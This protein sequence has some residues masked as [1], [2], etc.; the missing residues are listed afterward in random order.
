MK[1]FISIFVLF[2][3]SLSNI[4]AQQELPSPSYPCNAF[5]WVLNPGNV[6]Y[7]EIS[8][9]NLCAQTTYY[10]LPPCVLGYTCT[11]LSL[12]AA[13]AGGVTL[14]DSLPMSFSF[15]NS[16]TY[17]LIAKY[18]SNIQ[19][20]NTGTGPYR[21]TTTRAITVNVVNLADA[22]AFSLNINNLCPSPITNV[23]ITRSFP[24]NSL[25]GYQVKLYEL[26]GTTYVQRWA[27]AYT[28]GSFTTYNIAAQYNNFTAG[29]KYRVE[30]YAKPTDYGTC[31][32]D[33]SITTRDFTINPTPTIL[34]GN[35]VGSSISGCVSAGP[36]P[37]GATQMFN[38]TDSKMLF[39]P[40]VT[41]PP[42]APP[43]KKGVR[44]ELRKFN[45]NICS[46]SVNPADFDATYGISGV[47]TYFPQV[48]YNGQ[49]D[50]KTAYPTAAFANPGLYQLRLIL[51]NGLL[52]DPVTFCIRVDNG[53][54]PDPINVSMK[55]EFGNPQ[56]IP[57]TSAVC[58]T[59]MTN[60][61][62]A[63]TSLDGS[64]TSGHIDAYWLKIEDCGVNGVNCA[65]PSLV[66]D[67]ATSTL[68]AFQ[69]NLGLSDPN[70]GVYVK[71]RKPYPNVNYF[72]DNP[73]HVWKITMY[74]K[75]IC[76]TISK[77]WYFKNDN[78]A[79]R[80]ANITA[81]ESDVVGN[82]TV[83]T[84]PNPA[85][86]NTEIWYEAVEDK[87]AILQVFDMTGKVMIDQKV[88]LIAGK[89]TL[90]LAI[91]SYPAGVYFYKIGFLTGKIIKQ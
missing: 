7:S 5:A 50:L 48:P 57:A 22:S 83:T 71:S 24:N 14:I 61:C 15:Y 21:V 53:I 39:N 80:F 40:T 49:I 3:Y 6:V 42:C 59:P 88:G 69:C 12:S 27:S 84:V 19:Y 35:F 87:Q 89:N 8:T 26:V 28:S 33:Y 63:T 76:G 47:H 32:T 37:S 68:P 74:G 54:S 85:T 67:G 44:L 62:Q 58:A 90:P 46:G 34:A 72:Q 30:V 81:T 1:K 17:Q 29:A 60:V 38:C 91:Q 41:Y 75:N 25:A 73:Y 65:S 4:M 16:G 20:T 56:A 13:G 18:Q 51:S 78:T 64:S 36:S 77:T 45:A 70:L 23:S 9:M 31:S 86:D 43:V 79:C 52:N 66:V 10:L 55:D 11:G 2:L 82:E